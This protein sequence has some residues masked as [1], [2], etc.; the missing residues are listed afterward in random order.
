MLQ[1][2][3]LRILL[4]LAPHI[5]IYTD[6]PANLLTADKA[7]TTNDSNFLES[8]ILVGDIGQNNKF[9]ACSISQKI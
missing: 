9:D 6:L 2:P 5:P 7:E 3:G 4:K 1:V 8:L